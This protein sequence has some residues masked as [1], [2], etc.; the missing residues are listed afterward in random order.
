MAM[1]RVARLADVS[2]ALRAGEIVG[3]A[4]VSGN[5]PAV[6]RRVVGLL[7]PTSVSW[8]CWAPSRRRRG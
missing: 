2:L 7:E 4:G 1:P 3:I 5:R 8:S 6:A